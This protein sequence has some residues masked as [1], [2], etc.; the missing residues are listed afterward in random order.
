MANLKVFKLIT[1]EEIVAEV[2]EYVISEV[3]IQNAILLLLQQ[4]QQG[5]GISALPWGN[6]VKNGTVN[7][8]DEHIIYSGEPREELV[9]LWTQATSSLALPQSGLITG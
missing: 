1:G 9:K 4:T 2:V 3:R 7:I 8:H 6:H 5:I